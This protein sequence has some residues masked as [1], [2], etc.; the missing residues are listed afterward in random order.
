MSNSKLYFAVTLAAILGISA[1]AATSCTGT[2]SAYKPSVLPG[3]IAFSSDRN[4]IVHIYTVKPDSTDLKTTSSDNNTLDGLPSW[5]PDGK[6]MLFTSNQSDDN[7]IW[8]MNEDGSDRKRLTSIKGWNGLAR[9]SPDGSKIVFAGELRAEEGIS[10]FHIYIMNADGSNPLQLTMDEESHS[11]E[12]SES[13][14]HTHSHRKIWNSAPT[15]S[16]DS[17]KILFST[18]R[19]TVDVSPVLYTMNTDGSAQQ[20][21]GFIFPIDGTTP[22]WSPVTNKIVFVRGSAAKGDIWVMDAGS[23]FPGWTAKK[24]TD[25]I[26]N[27]HSPVWSP[28][29]TQIAFVS[30]TYGSDDI[31][32]MNADGSNVRRVS[33]DASADRQPT[34]R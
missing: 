28:D 29:G 4:N 18:N 10:Q 21:F 3:L 14:E 26:D 7:E 13:G 1:L 8:S 17:S 25:N 6:R 23:P 16:P 5:T 2:P 34:W 31:F 30:D 15:W 33:Y 12:E 22:D 32:V 24:I 9:M 11:D 19:E 20:R 27:N